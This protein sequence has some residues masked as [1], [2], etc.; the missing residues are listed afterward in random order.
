MAGCRIQ[1]AQFGKFDGFDIV[2]S[3]VSLATTAYEDLPTPIVQ[4]LKTMYF[5]DGGV[6]EG[7]TYYY[8][9]IARLGE[10]YAISDE[11]SITIPSSNP[12]ADP[13]WLDVVLMIYA[14]S[15]PIVDA[16]NSAKAVTLSPSNPIY[17]SSELYTDLGAI[18]LDGLNGMN[19]GVSD[20]GIGVSDFTIECYIKI[21][22]TRNDPFYARII[23]LNSAILF[24]HG[25]DY[26]MVFGRTNPP[27]FQSIGNLRN[28]W[29]HVCIMRLNGIAYFFLHG[30]LFNTLSYSDTVYGVFFGGGGVSNRSTKAYF[31][32][33]RITKVARY[34]VEGFT[35]PDKKFPDF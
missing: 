7:I 11:V 6:E 29:F 33:C 35:P 4:N 5:E 30:T 16:S 8:L 23:D 21:H 14:D 2:R 3:T 26:D 34:P 17:D 20:S 18:Y 32:C 10:S 13:Y 31:N 19:F 9:V 25:W 12:D 15:L 28:N 24:A 22:P 27:P 1:F